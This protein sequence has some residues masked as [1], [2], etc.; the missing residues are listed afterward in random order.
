MTHSR[1]PPPIDTMQHHT[2][3]R[4]L[5]IYII[6]TLLCLTG[7]QAQP[8]LTSDIPSVKGYQIKVKDIDFNK[9]FHVENVHPDKLYLFGHYGS[10]VY[11]LDSAI[12]RK[13]TAVF[14]SKKTIPCGVYT[15]TSDNKV[16]LREIILN[17]DNKFTYNLA[18]DR[19]EGSEENQLL[20]QFL[21]KSGNG[22]ISELCRELNE[23]MPSSFV[24]KYVMSIYGVS[25]LDNIPYTDRML[26][27]LDAADLSDPRI[28][29]SH[30]KAWSLLNTQNYEL[31]SDNTDS[32]IHYI[33]RMLNRPMCTP[34]RDYIVR[35]LFQNFDVHNPDYDPGLIYLYDNFDKSWIEEGREGRYKRKID[36]LRK[37]VP[38]AQIPELISHD[39]N[40]KAHSTSEIQKHYTVLWFWDPD[41]DHCQEM[42]PV[43]HT[44]YQEHS[45][46]WDFEV[47]A[48]EVN[49]D[50]DRW[51]AFSNQHQLWD[52]TNL[53]T[54]MGDQNLD[55]IEYFDI[56]TTP[57]V[58]LIDNSKKHTIIARQITLDEL[59]HFFETNQEKK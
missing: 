8:T 12:V 16:G 49:D 4:S 28:L 29:F 32:L 39:K 25:H 3:R 34:V 52:W 14:K 57:V 2:M 20:E 24:S 31:E 15:I 21:I 37:I 36:N 7:L 40:G 48:V 6:T 26:L 59:E 19:V 44:M 46:E 10:D 55:F 23:A 51:V 18:D 27:C 54:S 43:L 38:G 13:S 5:Y 35:S 53:S 22:N 41:C 45:D 33:D 9:R 30:P 1:V 50:H 56:M 17:H 58:F 47:F 42:T 11:L